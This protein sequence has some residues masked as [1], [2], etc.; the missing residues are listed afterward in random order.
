MMTARDKN[1]IKSTLSTEI[2]K[3]YTNI[4]ELVINA[5]QLGLNTTE[6]SDKVGKWNL[7]K[8]IYELE[9]KQACLRLIKLEYAF[10][11]VNT[12]SFGVCSACSEEIPIERIVLEPEIPYCSNCLEMEEKETG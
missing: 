9:L 1:K 6:R 8:R 5:K 12:D 10:S 2:S 11:V 4:E 3:A 7:R